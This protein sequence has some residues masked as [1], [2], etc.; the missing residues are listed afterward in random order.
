[1]R[2][3][4]DPRR[5]HEKDSAGESGDYGRVRHQEQWRRVNEHVVER[6]SHRLECSLHRLAAE[7]LRRVGWGL[8]RR[9]DE[10]SL[11]TPLLQGVRE[12]HAADED[13]GQTD[14]SLDAHVL[15]H[16]GQP[17]VS[18]HQ[19]HAGP[20]LRERDREIGRCGGLSVAGA[21]AGDHE[22]A[23]VAVDVDELQIRS[24]AS[25]RLGPRVP[26]IGVNDERT[27]LRLGVESD[28]AEHGFV[29]SGLD[30]V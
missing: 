9:E 1:M 16:A 22:R 2:F 12:V 23:R 11:V 4:R 3:A 14:G 19:R 5:C 20:R 24:K 17:Q 18:I 28:S 21:G 6:A 29:R 8:A 7:Q 15:G 27:L 30:I 25:E 13:I 10:E 26:W